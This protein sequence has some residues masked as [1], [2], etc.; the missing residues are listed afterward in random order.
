MV[1]GE[2]DGRATLG[3][4]IFN[5]LEHQA[6]K[7]RPAEIELAA[8]IAVRFD[9]SLRCVGHDGQIQPSI[10]ALERDNFAG[11]LRAVQAPGELRARRA[12]FGTLLPIAIQY[13][14]PQIPV[15]G[16]RYGP[17]PTTSCDFEQIKYQ[18][19][20]FHVIVTCLFMQVSK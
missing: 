7:E 17:N 10:H 4:S 19:S 3:Y 8:D 5:I 16:H 12:K 13:E 6:A 18:P 1:C 14:L 15:C 9:H 2:N 20:L 11:V